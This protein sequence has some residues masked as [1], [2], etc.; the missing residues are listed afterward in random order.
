MQPEVLEFLQCPVTQEKLT[1]ANEKVLAKLNELVRAG[2]L[3]AV[4]GKQAVSELEG[5]LLCNAGKR[6][7]PIRGGIPLLLA[8]EAFELESEISE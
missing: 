8:S 1:L 7:Y 5:A 4:D 3:I 2:D 6:V